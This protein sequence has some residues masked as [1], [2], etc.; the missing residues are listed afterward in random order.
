VRLVL[1]CR[2]KVFRA[3]KFRYACDRGLDDQIDRR[4]ARNLVKSQRFFDRK[5]K[6]FA[7]VM[8]EQLQNFRKRTIRRPRFELHVGILSSLAGSYFVLP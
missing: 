5:L 6:Q 7:E 2:P 3:S 8:K 4:S 1:F